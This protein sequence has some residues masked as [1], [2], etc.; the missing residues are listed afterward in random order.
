MKYKVSDQ[1]LWDIYN[2]LEPLSD[3]LDIVTVPRTMN[4]F[5]H[6]VFQ[7][8]NPEWVR[9]K[10]ELGSRK[11]SQ[12]LYY[13]K[14]KNYIRAKNLEGREGIIVTKNGFAKILRAGFHFKNVPKRKDGKYIM[15]IFDI[16]QGYKKARALLMNILKNLGYRLFQHSVWVTPCDVLNK[17]ERLLQRHSL[18][19]FVRI[20]LIEKI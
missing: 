14:R 17:T 12:L 11:F 10:K 2:F 18:D 9:Y 3:V 20:F 6:R 1:F 7:E 5:V 4:H 15:V 19:N 16:P 8:Q 13:L